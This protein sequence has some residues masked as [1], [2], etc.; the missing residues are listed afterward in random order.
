MGIVERIPG[1]RPGHRVRNIVVLALWI[2]V[3]LPFGF[4]LLLLPLAEPLLLIVYLLCAGLLAIGFGWFGLRERGADTLLNRIPLLYSEGRRAKLASAGYA[5]LIF[6]VGFG[7]IV[8][9][10]GPTPAV[11]NSTESIEA[12]TAETTIASTSMS[13]TPT[14]RTST[15]TATTSST[16][17]AT[18]TSSP[19]PVSTPTSTVTRT[20]ATPTATP[21]PTPTASPTPTATP[22]PTPTQTATP[23]RGPASGT[24]WAVEVTRVVDGD[25]MEVRF[26]N[27]EVD[28]LRLLGVDTPETYGSNDPAEFEGI[29]NS[30]AGEDH[31]ANW[32]DR[33]SSFATDELDGETVRIEVDPQ[34]DRR[35]SY[36]RPLVYL[37]VDGQDFNRQLIDQGL[38]RMYDSSFS[39][40][41]VYTSAERQAQQD[42]VGL[43][44]YE[45]S[46]ATETPTPESS[47]G[48]SDL[49]PPSGGSSDPYDCGDF[50]TQEQ[51]QQVLKNTPG[52][53]SGLDDDDDGEACESLD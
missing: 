49:P 7:A 5:I 19:T 33:A 47:S 53:P 29:P 45:G 48:D 38:A 30:V 20:T 26:P 4:G 11:N 42:D 22:S 25:T 44:D 35:G 40:R 31:L 18:R 51:A 3:I 2:F 50:D 39:K 24:E 28:T 17:S 12:T 36:G 46:T 52:D 37:Y 34:A 8:G 43:W 6:F 21:T 23:A 41:S 9:G 13:P 16:L 15:D 27:G 32:G 10:S 1:T 14:T